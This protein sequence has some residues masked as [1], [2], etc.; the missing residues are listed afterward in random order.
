[1]KVAAQLP[2][3]DLDPEY[4]QL[5]KKH[6]MHGPCGCLNPSH[7]CMKH[8]ECRFGYPKRLQN[9]TT[10]TADGYTQ[11]ARPFGRSVQMTDTFT[12]DNSW[13]VPH[14]KFLLC[15][16]NAHINVECSASISVVEYMFSYVYKG[17]QTS[18]A[19]SVTPA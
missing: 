11:L 8:G 1:M 4:F 17:T 13:V 16:Y 18:T 6:M 10:I 3:A 19:N 15:K 5:V 7:Y 12:A 9:V 2:D 14:N